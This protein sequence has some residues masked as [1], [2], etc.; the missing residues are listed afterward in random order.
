MDNTY[1]TKMA[2]SFLEELSEIEKCGF[3]GTVGRFL[4]SGTRAIGKGL[5][6]VGKPGGLAKG[7]GGQGAAKAGGM[8]KH[9]KQIYERGGIKGVARS[10]YGKMVGAAAVP[11]AAS[12]FIGGG[13]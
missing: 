3:V 4:M 8:G 10:R 1:M 11:V 2:S 7:L 6:N 13:D 9:I 12:Q 5:A